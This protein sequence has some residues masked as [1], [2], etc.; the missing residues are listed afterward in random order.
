MHEANTHIFDTYSYAW[1]PFVSSFPCSSDRL[2][3][4]NLLWDETVGYAILAGVFVITSRELV[5][6]VAANWTTEPG[7]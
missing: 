2:R 3:L 7:V 4:A 5:G 6:E 1:Y